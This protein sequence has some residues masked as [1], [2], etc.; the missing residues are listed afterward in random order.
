M[1]CEEVDDLSGAY[2]LGALPPQE[3]EA[4]EA[5]LAT[6]L[7]SDHAELHELSATAAMLPFIVPPLLDS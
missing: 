6:C 3:V 2:A 4:V 5:H 7:R 1:T